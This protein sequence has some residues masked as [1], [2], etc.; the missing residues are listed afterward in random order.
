MKLSAAFC[1]VAG[2]ASAWEFSPTPICTLSYGGESG[3][4]TVTYDPMLGDYAIS[5]TRANGLWPDAP[6]F[7]ILFAGPRQ[8]QIGT[9][10]HTLSDD[11]RTITATDKGFGNVL[12][13]LEF[14][15]FAIAQA[16]EVLFRFDLTDVAEPVQAFRNCGTELTS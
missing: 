15:T 16:G 1:L 5:L 8:I 7:G 6:I 12:D 13:G 11:Q 4:V 10:R 9:D 14:N 3:S 2:A